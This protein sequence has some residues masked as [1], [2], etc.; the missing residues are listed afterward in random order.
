MVPGCWLRRP[1]ADP[2]PADARARVCR[3]ARGAAPRDT[4]SLGLPPRRPP[5]G[6]DRRGGPCRTARAPADLGAHRGGLSLASDRFGRRTAPGEGRDHSDGRPLGGRA[7]STAEADG[8][9]VDWRCAARA[10]HAAHVRRLGVGARAGAHERS[11]RGSHRDDRGRHSGAPEVP[12]LLRRARRHAA[13]VQRRLDPD[14]RHPSAAPRRQRRHSEVRSDRRTG[15]GAAEGNARVVGDH[16]RPARRFV[17]R[18]AGGRSRRAGERN[19]HGALRAHRHDA[20]VEAHAPRGGSSR[21]RAH[22]AAG[23][24]RDLSLRG[25]GHGRGGRAHG[26]DHGRRVLDAG[27]RRSRVARWPAGRAHTRSGRPRERRILGSAGRLRQTHRAFAERRLLRHRRRRRGSHEPLRVRAE[28][29]A[30]ARGAGQGGR[31]VRARVLQRDLD[32]TVDRE[33]HDLA[34]TQRARWAPPRRAL[35]PRARSRDDDGGAHAEGWL[36]DRVVHLQP[37][38]RAPD[39]DRAW[40]GRAR[41]QRDRGPFDVFSR[42]PRTV[43]D[44]AEELPG[45]TLVGALPDDRRARAELAG[46][47]FRRHVR[48][49]RREG[50]AEGVARRGLPESRAPLRDD[51]HL[52]FLPAGLR[53]AGNRTGV[54]T[55]AHNAICTTR[56][57]RTRTRHSRSSWRS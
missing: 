55:T 33:L 1:D 53:H 2:H 9:P 31:R 36:P 35:D 34:P 28:D 38:R 49:S 18:S 42:A 10:R 26:G 44:V 37:E 50:T 27:D 46:G 3:S 43:L 39:R 29:D 20:H 56:R 52:P 15:G 12:A 54:C 22:R 30:R 14:L 23:R 51:E 32:P 25:E 16:A 41:R 5:D 40:H 57:W 24:D 6:G 4:G 13:P 17:R 45:R 48:R 21:R 19:A 8:P 11:L 7:R 47:A